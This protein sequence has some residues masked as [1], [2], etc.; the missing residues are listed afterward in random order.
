MVR[1]SGKLSPSL[2]GRRVTVES[3]M[4]C[5]AIGELFLSCKALVWIV[6]G[7]FEA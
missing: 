6:H 7:Q 2:I 4:P 3:F 5:A 1:Y